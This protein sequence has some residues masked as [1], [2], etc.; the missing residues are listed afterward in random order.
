VRMFQFGRFPA[1]SFHPHTCADT[2]RPC[3]SPHTGNNPDNHF[4]I[5]ACTPS[6]SMPTNAEKPDAEI[7]PEPTLREIDPNEFETLRRGQMCTFTSAQ[8]RC[9][10][11]FSLA[12]S[13]HH[14]H[15]MIIQVKHRDWVFL[16]L[17]EWC[18]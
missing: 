4:F 14:A 6:L 18:S 12:S 11:L 2:T 13:F 15:A 10:L 1:L 9:A 5:D 17:A 16:V 7:F 3:P 8:Y